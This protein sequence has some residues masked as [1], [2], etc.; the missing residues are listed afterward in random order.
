MSNIN[1]MIIGDSN[2]GKTN[3]CTRYVNDQF[4]EYINPTIAAD[5]FN[6]AL[7]IKEH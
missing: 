3:L 7:V 6:R 4:S 2:V 1:L 5:L